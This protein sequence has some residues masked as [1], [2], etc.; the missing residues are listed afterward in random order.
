MQVVRVRDP[1]QFAESG[2]TAAVDLEM[3]ANKK[4]AEEC[5]LT[6]TQD[7]DVRLGGPRHPW[8]DSVAR[9]SS[10]EDRPQTSKNIRRKGLRFL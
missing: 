5:T 9:E 1:A 2:G 7:A 3:N 8:S 6:L 10:S 4:K